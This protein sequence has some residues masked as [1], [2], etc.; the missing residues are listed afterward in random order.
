M[1]IIVP[2]LAE[3]SIT[4]FIGAAEKIV[5][6]NGRSK[7]FRFEVWRTGQQQRCLIDG[8]PVDWAKFTTTGQKL[9][10]QYVAFLQS[11]FRLA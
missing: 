8:R 10:H 9:A 11:G 5:T 7:T 2:P 3:T 1:E 6:R 4:G